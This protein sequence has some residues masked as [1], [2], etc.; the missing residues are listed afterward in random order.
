VQ[1]S[2]EE[3]SP[4]ESDLVESSIADSVLSLTSA[5]I[6]KIEDL[7]YA[8]DILDENGN[9]IYLQLS[10]DNISQTYTRL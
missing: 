5:N 10:G 9:L 4:S 3:L 2:S 7:E 1:A 8:A 6:E